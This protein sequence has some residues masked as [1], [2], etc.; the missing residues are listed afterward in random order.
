MTGI[1]LAIINILLAHGTGETAGTLTFVRTIRTDHASTAITA[2][3][4]STGV[5]VILT[6]VTA[7]AIGAITLETLGSIAT[8]AMHAGFISTG[9]YFILAQTSRPALLTFAS[10]ATLGRFFDT[11]SRIL[12]RIFIGAGVNFVL[13]IGTIETRRTHAGVITLAGIET[14][15]IILAGMMMGA[16]VEILVAVDTTPA[17]LAN[18]FPGFFTCAV[19]AF[20]MGYTFVAERSFPA[21]MTAKKRKKRNGEINTSENILKNLLF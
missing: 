2:R 21:K 14:G 9:Y 5:N 15:S 1:S 16:V 17:F 4:G 7:I 13:T 3:I 20:G 12:A 18:A 11:S 6:H 8:R 10:V 19:N